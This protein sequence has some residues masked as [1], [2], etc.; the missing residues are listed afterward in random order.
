[1]LKAAREG[2][3]C[4]EVKVLPGPGCA[5]DPTKQTRWEK[6]VLSSDYAV[7]AVPS[8]GR[9]LHPPTSDLKTPYKLK[10]SVRKVLFL[11]L[12]PPC[13]HRGSGGNTPEPSE[14]PPKANH[15]PEKAENPSPALWKRVI[16]KPELF[17][18]P[19]SEFT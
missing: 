17:L 9:L 5:Q 1:M 8:H 10:K 15:T 7:L 4:P 3:S 12:S 13:C 19:E 14:A 18:H 11:S 16:S 2:L 6:A